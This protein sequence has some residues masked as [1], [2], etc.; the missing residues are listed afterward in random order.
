MWLFRPID[1][2]PNEECISIKHGQQQ[3]KIIRPKQKNKYCDPQGNL[4]NDPDLIQEVQ[5]G[6]ALM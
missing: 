2:A 5:R 4:I 3:T 6:E 1:E